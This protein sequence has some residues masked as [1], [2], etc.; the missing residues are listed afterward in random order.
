[1]PHLCFIQTREISPPEEAWI[2]MIWSFRLVPLILV[3][4][5]IFLGSDK[6][7]TASFVNREIWT[8]IVYLNKN[9]WNWSFFC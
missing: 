7:D 4:H 3:F 6:K 9:C 2:I 5:P 1:M 8:D